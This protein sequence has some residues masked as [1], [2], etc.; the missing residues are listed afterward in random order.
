MREA[1]KMSPCGV[2]KIVAL[3]LAIDPWVGLSNI[4]WCTCAFKK[5]KLGRIM[6]SNSWPEGYGQLYVNVLFASLGLAATIA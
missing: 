5:D 3:L 4:L 6:L 1:V 2:E